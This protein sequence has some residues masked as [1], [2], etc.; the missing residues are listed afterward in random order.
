MKYGQRG[1]DSKTGERDWDRERR[2]RK[3]RNRI[4]EKHERENKE[5]SGAVKERK[6]EK[7]KYRKGLTGGLSNDSKSDFNY[8]N[9]PGETPSLNFP[10]LQ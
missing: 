10:P 9:N 5:G 3:K 6:K 8:L 1:K 4:K 7:W 2:R